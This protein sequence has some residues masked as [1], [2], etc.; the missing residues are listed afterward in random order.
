[1]DGR[2]GGGCDPPVHWI[3]LSGCGFELTTRLIAGE[4]P[5]S[6]L[7]ASGAGQSRFATRSWTSGYG[8]LHESTI[9]C[10]IPSGCPTR[11]AWDRIIRWSGRR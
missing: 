9:S 11:C 4:E 10:F 1:M 7:P 5:R 3:E 8:S 2:N 6:S